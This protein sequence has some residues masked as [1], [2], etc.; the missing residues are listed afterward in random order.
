MTLEAVI[1]AVKEETGCETT[2]K[3]HLKDLGI[4]SLDFLSLVQRLNIPDLLV[5]GINTVNDLFHAANGEI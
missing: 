3:T 2:G 4:D 1:E 5:P